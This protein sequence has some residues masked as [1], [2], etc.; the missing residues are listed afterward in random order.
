MEEFQEQEYEV[1]RKLEEERI[2]RGTL[3]KRGLA[4]GA[5]RTGRLESITWY[6]VPG[7]STFLSAGAVQVG[8]WSRTGSARRATPACS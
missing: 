5:G 7:A 3:L 1:L 2:G 8:R 6:L 4:A